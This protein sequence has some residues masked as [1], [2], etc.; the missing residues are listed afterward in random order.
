MIKRYGPSVSLLAVLLLQC[1]SILCLHLVNV[2]SLWCFYRESLL[3]L[4]FLLIGR[5]L[6]GF[7]PS[8]LLWMESKVL[9]KSI[10][11]NVTCRFFARTPLR[12][13]RIVNICDVVGLIS[14]EAILFFPKNVV[15]FLG[16]TRFRS[17]AL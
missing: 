4:R 11:S 5:T 10:N 7:V 6:V 16:S 13:L 1:R 12:I 3:L 8:S 9:V 17:R 15:K 14:S 2:L